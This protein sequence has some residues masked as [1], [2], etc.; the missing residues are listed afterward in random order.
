[1]KFYIIIF[2]ICNEQNCKPGYVLD[3]HLSSPIV[4]NRLKRPTR[5]LSGQLIVFCSVLLR[6][7]FTCACNVTITAVVS[8]SAFPPLPY[9]I[10]R[11]I[12]V[13]LALESPLP[14]VIWHPALWSPDFPYLRT[15]ANSS[16]DYLSYSIH[17]YFITITI[18]CKQNY[19]TNLLTFV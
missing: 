18:F 7:G 12:S 16:H 6:M 8:Y 17:Y 9:R 13:A 19:I 4:A 2:I 10:W 14:D 11:F 3:N 1:M 15:F 5:K